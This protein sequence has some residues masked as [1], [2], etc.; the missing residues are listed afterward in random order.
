MLS[1]TERRR[2]SPGM[3]AGSRIVGYS[4][5]HSHV[6][7]HREWRNQLT[8]QQGFSDPY[9]MMQL[10]FDKKEDAIRFCKTQ[11]YDYVVEEL[12]PQFPPVFKQYADKIQPPAI[13]AKMREVGSSLEN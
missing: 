13:L 12:P 10:K 11:G 8:G 7:A 6:A 1:R 5:F 3:C 4:I 2:S 9:D